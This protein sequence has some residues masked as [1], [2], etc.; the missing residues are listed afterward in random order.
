MNITDILKSILM[1][2]MGGTST[3]T[4]QSGGMSSLAKLAIPMIL[5]AL[6][7]NAT[8]RKKAESL[9]EALGQ[10]ENTDVASQISDDIFRKID[11]ADVNDGTKILKHVLGKD[12]DAIAEQ[13]AEKA[14]VS[15]EKAI[16][17]MGSLAPVIMEMLA[18]KTKNNRTQESIQETLREELNQIDNEPDLPQLPDIFKDMLQGKTQKKKQA[19]GGIGGFLKDLMGGQA[20]EEEEDDNGG[21]L[22]SLGGMGGVVDILGKM[23]GK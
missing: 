15:K 13:I 21:L 12:N 10:H 11:T 8:S 22:D 9:K 5:M 6:F 20:E 7:K 2:K 17:M 23:M 14:G 3:R 19:E 1:N 18:E 16:D 4:Q